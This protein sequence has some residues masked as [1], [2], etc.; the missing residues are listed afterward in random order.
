MI[1]FRLISAL[2]LLTWGGHAL[3]DAVDIALSDKSARFHYNS[4]VAQSQDLNVEM[5]YLYNTDNTHLFVLGLNVIG[6]SSDV[7]GLSASIGGRL[8]SASTKPENNGKNELAALALG[9]DIR[10]KFPDKPLGVAAYAYYAPK[11]VSFLDADRLSEVGLRAEYQMLP[12]AYVYLGYREIRATLENG[13]DLT[14]DNGGHI[15][16]RIQF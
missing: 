4:G 1:F 11:I 6:Q 14:V 15:G 9:T 5:G 2:C 13:P 16:L 3:A 8:Y 10:Y 12:Q 7:S